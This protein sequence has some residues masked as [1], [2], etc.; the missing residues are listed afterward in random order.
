L[1]DGRRHTLKLEAKSIHYAAVLYYG[2]TVSLPGEKPPFDSTTVL[3]VKPLFTC[4]MKT[5][6]HGRTGKRSD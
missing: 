5:P 2:N 3:E 1:P 6:W 4:G